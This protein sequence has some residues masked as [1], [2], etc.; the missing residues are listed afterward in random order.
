MIVG[1]SKTA[2]L[3]LDKLTIA[4]PIGAG[5]V[6]VTEPVADWPV[7]RIEVLSESDASVLAANDVTV[8]TPRASYPYARPSFVISS[9]RAE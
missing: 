3:E 8:R 2:L 4:P 6:R 7:Y 5:A 1:G 9:L